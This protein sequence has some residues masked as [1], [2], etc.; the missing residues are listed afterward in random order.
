MGL[1]KTDSGLNQTC[2]QNGLRLNLMFFGVF[3]FFFV[4]FLHRMGTNENSKG[5]FFQTVANTS[6]EYEVDL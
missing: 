6:D 2:V 4:F 5:V 3:R 1:F